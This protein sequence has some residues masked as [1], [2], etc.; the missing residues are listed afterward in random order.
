MGKDGQLNKFLSKI[1]ADLL[2]MKLEIL[3][4]FCVA[5]SP[6]L[7]CGLVFD[8]FR[9]FLLG[10]KESIGNGTQQQD[11]DANQ[12]WIDSFHKI[13]SDTNFTTSAPTRKDEVSTV[14]AEVAA[15]VVAEVVTIPSIT[16][17]GAVSLL[18]EKL[19]KFVS[20]SMEP[21][22]KFLTETEKRVMVDLIKAAALMDPIYERQV[23]TEN[24]RRMEELAVA[25]TS[26]SKL[27]LEYM[28]I[29]GGPW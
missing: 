7:V 25:G 27:Q 13:I 21:D 15:E 14:V 3:S 19:D 23:W 26:L 11:G 1:L 2:I 29:M 22:Y 9:S 20:V 28:Y 18:K 12:T 10:L 16:Q 17:S 8:P 24:P 6:S 5:L 4:I